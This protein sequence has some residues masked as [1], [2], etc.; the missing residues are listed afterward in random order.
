VPVFDGKP[1]N[2]DRWEIQWNA[3]VAVEEIRGA[4]EYVLNG[5]M[6]E[7]SNPVI[8]ATA[9]LMMAPCCLC[10]SNIEVSIISFL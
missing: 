7:D 5:D 9:M 1:E 2:P 4:Q 3:F 6:P 8:P 10:L